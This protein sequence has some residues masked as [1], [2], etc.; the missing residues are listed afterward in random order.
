MHALDQKKEM[1]VYRYVMN[2]TIEQGI[3]EL[4]KES[5][6]FVGVAEIE[7]QLLQLEAERLN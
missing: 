6:S 4:P 1:F 3:F 2:D 7:D 5:L